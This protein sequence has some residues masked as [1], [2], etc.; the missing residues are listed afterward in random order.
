MRHVRVSLW[1]VVLVV[2]ACSYAPLPAI[3]GSVDAGGGG[4]GSAGDIPPFSELLAGN[5]GGP[6]NVDGAGMTARFDGPAY[7]AIDRAGNLYVSDARNHTIR[8]ITAAGMVSTLAGTAGVIGSADGTGP[9]ASFNHP[10]GVAVDSDSDVFVADQGNHT[11]RLVTTDGVVTTL[12][13][14][15]GTAGSADGAGDQARFNSPSGLGLWLSDDA[16]LGIYIADTGN[17]TIRHMGKAGGVATIAG[18]AGMPG[19]VDARDV[20]ARFNSPSG[21]T[22]DRDG[23]IYVADT[24]N[25][26][27]RS[28]TPGAVM[29]TTIAGTPGTTGR[30]DGTGAAASFDQPTSIYLDPGHV[31]WVADQTNDVIRAVNGTD[32][33]TP[34]DTTAKLAAPTSAAV[35]AVGNVYIADTNN[36]TIRKLATDGTLTTFVGA[37]FSAGSSDGTGAAASFDGAIGVAVDAAGNTYVADHNNHTIR[38]VTSGGVTTTFAGTAGQFGTIDGVGIK[39]QFDA[40]AGLAIDATGKL[41]VSDQDNH[42]IRTISSTGIVATLAGTAQTFGSVDG[43]G[44]AAR[45]AMPSGIAV[46]HAGTVYV[47]DRQNH[48]LRKITG[49]VVTTLAGAAGT[50]GSADGLGTAAR[51]DTPLGVAVGADGNVYVADSANH[52]IRKVTPDGNVTTFAGAA[53]IAGSTDGLGTAARFHTPAGLAI[54]PSGDLYVA[55]L[56]NHVIRKITPAGE[57]TTIAGAPAIIGTEVGA[58]TSFTDPTALAITG[59]SLVIGDRN[60]IIDLH[61]VVR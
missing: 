57:V 14:V 17:H 58:M 48:N 34:V 47:A 26:T 43:S 55:D 19:S 32:V 35:D 59:D 22:G 23:N 5:L 56:G 7:I 16:E 31:L 53:G 25:N 44:P 10:A 8:K 45:F 28:I 3:P 41:Y 60:A 2:S 54:D 42:T 12:A 1:L 52:S 30:A 39:A 27:I 50:A 38:M 9:A 33:S 37:A 6:G 20:N 4:D 13:G 49:S 51:F 18:T 46:D 61:H 29:V 11:I 15:A 40:P 36:D 21:V 24:G